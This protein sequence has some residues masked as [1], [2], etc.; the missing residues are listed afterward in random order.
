MIE[1]EKVKNE[2]VRQLKPM[3]VEKIILF[4]SYANGTA[5]E[6]SDI[7]LY[8]V[9]DD[10]FIPRNWREKMDIKL[11]V[12]RSLRDLQTRYDID[13]IAHTKKMHEKFI[14]MGSVFSKEIME[15][16]RVIYG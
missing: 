6:E 1:I 3:G 12:A 5:R 16:G 7:D 10:D 9:T 14:E 13:L 11:K 8:V 2:I 15:K 4:G